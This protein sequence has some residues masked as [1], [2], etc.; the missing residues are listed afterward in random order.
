MMEKAWVQSITGIAVA[1][2]IAST[3]LAS[4]EELE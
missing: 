2:I 1:M 3:S 4:E